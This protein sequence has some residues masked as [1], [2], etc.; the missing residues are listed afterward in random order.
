MPFHV[1]HT[2]MPV[3]IQPTTE[4]A[5]IFGEQPGRYY[6]AVEKAESEGRFA[7]Q[8]G[9]FLNAADVLVDEG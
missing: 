6:A 2:G 9:M 3:R 8:P 7:D 4:P 1:M 5:G